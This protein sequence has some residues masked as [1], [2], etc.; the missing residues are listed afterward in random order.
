MSLRYF[1]LAWAVGAAMVL[2]SCGDP[3]TSFGNSAPTSTSSA[4]AGT[5]AAPQRI[6][7]TATQ[8]KLGSG[9]KLRVIVF[10]EED[11]SGEF[12]VDGTGIVAM[13]LI[14]QIN[15]QGRTVRD[16]EKSVAV[17]LKD[18]YLVDP[19]VSAEIINYRPFSIIGEV[20]DAGTYP[21]KNGMTLVDAVAEAGGFSYRANQRKVLIT[22]EGGNLPTEYSA[23]QSLPIFPGDQIVI[24]ERF[25]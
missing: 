15:V 17:K 21:Y 13:P 14:G 7:R 22:Q 3:D 9:D 24:P 18:G 25:F 5:T 11:L 2:A 20:N 1:N 16:F 12:D 6:A 19:R 10:G 8:Y 4:A 23:D